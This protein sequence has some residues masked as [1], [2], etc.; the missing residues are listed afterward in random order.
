MPSTI[1]TEFSTPQL[2]THLCVIGC[3]AFAVQLPRQSKSEA[4]A[5]KGVYLEPP[6][7]VVYKIL[8]SNVGPEKEPI[9]CIVRPQVRFD[10][11]C[12]LRASGPEYI[13]E[14]EREVRED[15]SDMHYQRAYDA[16]QMEQKK[17]ILTLSSWPI[18]KSSLI[19]VMIVLVLILILLL[20]MSQK[21]LSRDQLMMKI[22]AVI[23]LTGLP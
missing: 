20:Q 9:Y 19:W 8:V 13:M 21:R 1:E 14:E 11:T 10:E 3:P 2:V 22:L 4:Q 7:L 15:A 6:D 5:V 16:F 17:F 23:P 18:T 12:I